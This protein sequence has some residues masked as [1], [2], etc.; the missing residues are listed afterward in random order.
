MNTRMDRSRLHIGAY[1]LQ[2]YARTEE[3]VKDVAESGVD[4][5]IYVHSGAYE[6]FDLFEKYGLGVVTWGPLPHWRSGSS[7]S[8]YSFLLYVSV[9]VPVIG[10]N[11][12]FAK[13]L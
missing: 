8:V 12:D 10:L 11:P 9:F 5:M 13:S 1:L 2:A 6:T 7:M 4:H 3:H